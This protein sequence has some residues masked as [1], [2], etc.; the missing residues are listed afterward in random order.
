MLDGFCGRLNKLL[1]SFVSDVMGC[2]F[3][4]LVSGEVA[5]K[6]HDE[7]KWQANARSHKDSLNEWRKRKE[8]EGSSG[9]RGTSAVGSCRR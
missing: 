9:F 5:S 6:L 1:Q 2:P 4:H 8:M 3:G 7:R